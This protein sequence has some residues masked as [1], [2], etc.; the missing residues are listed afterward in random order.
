MLNLCG[1]VESGAVKLVLKV[2][3]GFCRMNYIVDHFCYSVRSAEA[4]NCQVRS[5]EKEVS[6]LGVRNDYL[7]EKS[8]LTPLVV[9]MILIFCL[10]L[11]SVYL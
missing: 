11:F 4:S 8:P 3:D 5:M 1:Y 2:Y 9:Q 6:Y 10:L 7:P